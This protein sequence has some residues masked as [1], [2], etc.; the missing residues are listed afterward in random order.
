MAALAAGTSYPKPHG[1]FW[2]YQEPEAAPDEGRR[3]QT[4]AVDEAQK[5]EIYVPPGPAASP[6]LYKPGGCTPAACKHLANDALLHFFF[7]IFYFLLVWQRVSQSAWGRAGRSPP[8]RGRTHLQVASSFWDLLVSILS[9]AAAAFSCRLRRS[10]FTPLPLGLYLNIFT[11]Q[12]KSL[13]FRER[14]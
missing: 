12:I 2:H 9:R 13:H 10:S 6:T 5:K 3:K 4:P 8:S 7:L 1:G 14:R 11:H